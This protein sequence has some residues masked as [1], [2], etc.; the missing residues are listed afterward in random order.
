LG[1][2]LINDEHH[3]TAAGASC[4]AWLMKRGR[5]DWNIDLI[6]KDHPAWRDLY[7]DRLQLSG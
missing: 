7:P 4:Q 2:R 1:G 3:E 6:E 5:H